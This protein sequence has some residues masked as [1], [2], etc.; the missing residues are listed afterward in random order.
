MPALWFWFVALFLKLGGNSLAM[1]RLP[2]ALFGAAAVISLY[3]LLRGTWGRYAAT[4]GRAIMAFSVSNVHYS[5]LALN[6]ITTQFFW[7]TCFFFLLRGFRSRRRF[8]W[9]V[10][11]LSAGLS[12]YFYYGT[13][14]LPFILL[15]FV[16]FVPCCSLATKTKIRER[17]ARNGRKLFRRIRSAV[18]SLFSEPQSLFGER[19]QPSDLVRMFQLVSLVSKWLGKPFGRCFPRT[20]WESALMVHRTSY[21]MHHCFYLPKPRCL[22]QALHCFYG[23]GVIPLRFSCSLPALAY[24]SWAVH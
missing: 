18:G 15:A 4:A 2:A 9:A 20:C 12:E 16:V 13:R 8:D 6:N 5:R 14:L 11:G 22:C 19:N 21:S 7:A 23:I 17:S 24:C 10:A 3:A 1:L